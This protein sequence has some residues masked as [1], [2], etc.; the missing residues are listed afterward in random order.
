MTEKNNLLDRLLQN[1]WL[2]HAAFWLVVLC[3]APVT[4]GEGIDNI[5]EAFLYRGVGLPTKMAATYFLAY[6]Q[7]PKLFLKKKYVLFGLSFILSTFVFTVIY[8]FNNIYIAETLGGSEH[9]KESI[10]EIITSKYTVL[11]Y[12]LRAY[13]FGAI[14]IFIKMVK[15]RAAE[16]HQIELL[17]KEKTQAELNF[18]KAQI[19]PHFLFNTLNN[20]YAL[21]L[22]KSDRAPEVVSKL[23]EM[24]DYMLYQCKE[25]RVL[26]SKEIELLQ[27]YID[28]EKLRYGNRLTITFEHELAHKQGQ[29]APLLLVSLVENAFKHGVSNAMGDAVINIS[30]S[31]QDDQIHFRI[32]NTKETLV[33]KDE[34]QY[35][36]GIGLKNVSRQLELIYPEQYTMEVVEEATSYEVTLTIQG[37]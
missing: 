3:L 34:M 32:F 16:K 7:I 1:R 33:Q 36:E 21:T 15:N 28:L 4:S 2:T 13:F 35:K 18:L 25:P 8:R 10:I 9:P 31:M 22:N 14:F 12:F 20:L 23:S 24:L 26:L 37:T 6:Y 27:H 30:L 19:H 29:I 11:N 5:G 17:Q